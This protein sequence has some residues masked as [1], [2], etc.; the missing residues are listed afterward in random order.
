[1]IQPL[2]GLYLSCTQK[3][4]YYPGQISSHTCLLLSLTMSSL[5]YWGVCFFCV[6]FLSALLLSLSFSP[7]PVPPSCNLLK[8]FPPSRSWTQ[9]PTRSM[10]LPPWLTALVSIHEKMPTIP[11]RRMSCFWFDACATVCSVI[12]AID[13][14]CKV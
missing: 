11:E 1:M 10:T 3:R 14:V 12:H 9:S 13:N 5:L 6:F 2:R 4:E 7:S 8:T